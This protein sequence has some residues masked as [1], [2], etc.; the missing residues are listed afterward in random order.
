MTAREIAK[1][2]LGGIAFAAFLYAYMWA[3]ILV[4]WAWGEVT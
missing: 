3:L 1:I 4:G 2:I